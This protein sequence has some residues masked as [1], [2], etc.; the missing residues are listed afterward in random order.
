MSDN[1]IVIISTSDA[2]VR[3]GPTT[4]FV[5]FMNGLQNPFIT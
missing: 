4:R 2:H 5:S 3:L 1:N